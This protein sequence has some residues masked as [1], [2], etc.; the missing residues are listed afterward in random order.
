MEH[1]PDHGPVCMDC[2]IIVDACSQYTMIPN[3]ESIKG[4]YWVTNTIQ[5]D[6]RIMNEIPPGT[7]LMNWV[8]DCNNLMLTTSECIVSR[9]LC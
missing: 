8:Y 3:R 5:D 6:T 2:G 1:I 4:L 9:G 7:D